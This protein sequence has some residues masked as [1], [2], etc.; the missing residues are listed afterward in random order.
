MNAPSAHTTIA[1]LVEKLV[2]V[3]AHVNDT[4]A[5]EMLTFKGRKYAM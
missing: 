1:S 2:T 4:S 3:Q 5:G